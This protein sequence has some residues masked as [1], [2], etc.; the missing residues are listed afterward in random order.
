MEES[1]GGAIRAFVIDKVDGKTSSEMRELTPAD[2][3]D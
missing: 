1:M 2:L 3:P